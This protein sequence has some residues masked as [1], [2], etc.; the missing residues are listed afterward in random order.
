MLIFFFFRNFTTIILNFA[1]RCFRQDTCQMLFL[2]L[3]RILCLF[4]MYSAR[5][6]I[7]YVRDGIGFKEGALLNIY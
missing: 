6:L 3:F 2:Q 7:K 1:L 4:L 5:T